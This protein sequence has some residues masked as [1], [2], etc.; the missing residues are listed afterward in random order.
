LLIASIRRSVVI[1][2]IAVTVVLGGACRQGETAGSTAEPSE[3]QTR[4]ERGR[5]LVENVANCFLCHSEVDWAA[6]GAP[7]KPGRAGAGT[8]FPD[9]NL[10][11]RLVASNLTPDP[12]TGCGPV[13]RRRIRAR[14]SGGRRAGRPHFVSDHAV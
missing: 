1:G 7:P 6:E 12:E 5:Y 3:E 8:V 10:P 2:V 11:F 9:A 14:D 4:L 13:V